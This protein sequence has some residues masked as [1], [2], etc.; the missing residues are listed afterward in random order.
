MV[1]ILHCKGHEFDEYV[2]K[3]DDNEVPIN[4]W[5]LCS[6]CNL[7]VTRESAALFLEGKTC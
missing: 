6:H 4:R 7:R 2:Q 5:W 1:E 3:V